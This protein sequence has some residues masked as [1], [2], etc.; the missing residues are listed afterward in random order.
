MSGDD[1]L[2][3][4]AELQNLERLRL[5][6]GAMDRSVA[7]RRMQEAGI[8]SYAERRRLQ[9]TGRTEQ[10]NLKFRPADKKKFLAVADRLGLSLTECVELAMER[11]IASL[12]EKKPG[13]GP[14]ERGA[15]G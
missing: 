13:K 5:R 9:K 11:L 8:M 14:Q 4:G 7:T 10:T 3:D 6:F 12:D 2:E 1:D 15:H